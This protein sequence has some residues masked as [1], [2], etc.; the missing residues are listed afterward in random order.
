MQ[1][2]LEIKTC[3]L[4]PIVIDDLHW[5]RIPRE[6]GVLKMGSNMV[7]NFVKDLCNLNKIS[8]GVNKSASKEFHNTMCC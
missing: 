5:S 6:P 2:L 8:S 4:S 1:H 3:K 7:T